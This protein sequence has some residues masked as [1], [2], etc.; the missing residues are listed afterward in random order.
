MENSN[1]QARDFEGMKSPRKT[2]TL[3]ISHEVTPDSAKNNYKDFI[4]S[5]SQNPSKLMNISANQKL[6]KRG[7]ATKVS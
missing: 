4:S 1:E 7:S 3:G 5:L 6:A 2:Q